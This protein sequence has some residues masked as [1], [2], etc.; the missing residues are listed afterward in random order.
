I[1]AHEGAFH[2]RFASES[3]LDLGD[4]SPA[5]LSIPEYPHQGRIEATIVSVSGLTVTVSVADDLG[6]V[7]E[8]A[9]MQTDPT[10]LPRAL[11]ERLEE[12]GDAANP[13][14]NRLLGLLDPSG[15]T[16]PF[17][18]DALDPEQREAVGS[19]LGRDLTFVVAP[20]GTEKAMTLGVLAAELQRR[21]R[22][23][24]L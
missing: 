12:I 23:V 2:Y 1:A 24:L 22:T 3:P 5:D 20:P 11:I 17:E 14:G 4:D 21:G 18:D 7:V 10:L 19:A 8:R 6:A 15:E 9:R 13:A 16:E